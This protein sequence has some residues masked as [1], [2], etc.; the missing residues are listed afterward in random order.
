MR[1][2]AQHN[3]RTLT[4]LKALLPWNWF[5]RDVQIDALAERLADGPT[6]RARLADLPERLAAAFAT[7]GWAHW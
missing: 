7:V 3:V 1:E 4:V 5:K 6:G 2:L